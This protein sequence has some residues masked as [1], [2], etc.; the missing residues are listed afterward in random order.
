MV[1]VGIK[2]SLQI[3]THKYEFCCFTEPLTDGL[4]QLSIKLL[5]TDWEE[6][7]E[8]GL[9]TQS[10]LETF[11]LGFLDAI[12]GTYESL[13]SFKKNFKTLEK[14]KQM[15]LMLSGITLEIMSFLNGVESSKQTI[16]SVTEIAIL[17]RIFVSK[18][19]R[20][21]GT[22]KKLMQ[23]LIG[24]VNCDIYYTAVP[25]EKNRDFALEPIEPIGLNDA[26]YK[27]A[28]NRLLSFYSQFNA[29]ISFKSGIKTFYIIKK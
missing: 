13:C 20:N 9:V 1:N 25:M 3:G 11:E 7:A 14:D 5:R 19:T 2:D 24:Y 23:E 15:E 10:N 17:P 16:S 22:G 28:E 8:K 4:T 18:K 12:Y 21:K 6:K 26:K 27:R 29:E